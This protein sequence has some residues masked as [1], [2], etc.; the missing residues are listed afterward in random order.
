M[1]H[2]MRLQRRMWAALNG[3]VGKGFVSVFGVGHGL[4]A[5]SWVGARRAQWSKSTPQG[6]CLRVCGACAARFA[7]RICPCS[8]PG[9]GTLRPKGHPAYVAMG[10]HS[11]LCLAG[12]PACLHVLR[13][14]R[15][16][17]A[18]LCI[19]NIGFCNPSAISHLGHV[20]QYVVSMRCFLSPQTHVRWAGERVSGG[21]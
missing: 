16:P 9:L 3:D 8:K 15:L 7:V 11:C 13:R 6:A 19:G 12:W 14:A 5:L 17:V 21:T 10:K 1:V 20:L 18:W 4:S 2:V